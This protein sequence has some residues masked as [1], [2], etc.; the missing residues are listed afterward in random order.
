MNDVAKERSR[1]GEE[2]KESWKRKEEELKDTFQKREHELCEGVKCMSEKAAGEVMRKDKELREE[3]TKMMKE[4][5]E[6][7]GAR[8]LDQENSLE[9]Q[10]VQ[11]QQLSCEAREVKS[12][13]GHHSGKRR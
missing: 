3:T 5:E 1:R 4:F 6:R 7:T 13:P 12:K 2:E 11:I 8:L 9:L 10:R